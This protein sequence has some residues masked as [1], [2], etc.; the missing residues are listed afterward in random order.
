M[1]IIHLF[2]MGF[3]KNSLPKNFA[4][5]HKCKKKYT[6][7]QGKSQ[8]F[9]SWMT[10]MCSRC[11]PDLSPSLSCSTRQTNKSPKSILSLKVN[12]SVLPF[13]NGSSNVSDFVSFHSLL[14]PETVKKIKIFLKKVREKLL[15][16]YWF[17]K[18]FRY[19]LEFLGQMTTNCGPQL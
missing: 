10:F 16:F 19:F 7:L 14:S 3:V 13:S 6:W 5:K 15:V 1:Y 18:A 12:T 17:L 2:F 11:Q 8:F 9:W 4:K